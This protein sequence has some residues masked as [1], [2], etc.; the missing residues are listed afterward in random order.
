MASPSR[1]QDINNIYIWLFLD[2]Y[3]ANFWHI[4]QP[5]VTTEGFCM[6]LILL[7]DILHIMQHTVVD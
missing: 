5:K 6:M 3:F 4:C 7:L 2:I 1:Q